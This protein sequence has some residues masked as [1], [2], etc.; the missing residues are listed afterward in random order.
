M[1]MRSFPTSF[2]TLSAVVVLWLVTAAPSRAGFIVSGNDQTVSVGGTADISFFVTSD[3]SDQL[4]SFN[5]QLQITGATGHLEFSSSQPAAS[6]VAPQGPSCNSFVDEKSYVFYNHSLDAISP[7]FWGPP[8][9]TVY[10]NDTI[11]G[12]DTYYDST[13]NSVAATVPSS[14]SL[15]GRVTVY[16][17][18][19]LVAAG[20]SFQVALVPTSIGDFNSTYFADPNS[21]LIDYTSTP[22]TVSVVPAG[23]SPVPAPPSLVLACIG[24]LIGLLSPWRRRTTA[25]A[26]DVGS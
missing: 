6:L 10:P 19:N 20:E 23:A 14:P 24:A 26:S 22:V 1:T 8:L 11:T 21:N 15:L 12:G 2:Q 16:A 17:D 9:T 5:L 7:P 18:P 13:S 4:A 25:A 3:S